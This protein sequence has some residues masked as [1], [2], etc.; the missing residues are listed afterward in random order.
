[1]KNLEELEAIREKAF[2]DI[3]LRNQN[4]GTKIVIGMSTC[5]IA[6]GARKVLTTIIS[7][8]QSKDISDIEV[9]MTACI[10]LCTLEPIVEIYSEGNGKIT[11]VNID[12]DKAKRII[13][14]HI[15]NGKIINEFLMD[16][17]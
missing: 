10:G 3:D 17:N 8:V 9:S 5:G 4:K 13:D 14:E 1:M 12:S 11:Y 2:K 15:V 16:N 7:E 6:A